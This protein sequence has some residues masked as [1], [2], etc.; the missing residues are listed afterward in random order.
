MNNKVIDLSHNN[1]I[2]K[3]LV[4]ARDAG[5]RGVIHKLSEGVSMTDPTVKA[6]YTLSKDAG[7]LWGIY[8][9]LRPGDIGQQ[10]AHFLK[11]A[12]QL[13]V[14]DDSTLLACDFEKTIPLVDVLHFLQA[15][16]TATERS[17]VLYSGNYL[18][19]AGGAPACPPIVRYRLWMP[20]YGPEAVLPKGFDSYWL[21]QWTDKGKVAG[22]GGSVDL[23][24]FNGTDQQLAAEWSGK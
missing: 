11:K 10:V 18:K 1:V 5:V 21:W 22:I 6:R 8:H 13:Q 20:Q 14:M 17:P 12:E 15:I 9:F 3:D 2:A 24:H 7:L 23:N 4:P 16:E 19:D